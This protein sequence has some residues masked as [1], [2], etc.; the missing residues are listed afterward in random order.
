MSCFHW[1]PLRVVLQIC[2]SWVETRKLAATPRRQR[3]TEPIP[4]AGLFEKSDCATCAP[5]ISRLPPGSKVPRHQGLGEGDFG[6][7]RGWWIRDA[8][9]HGALFDHWALS[10]PLSGNTSAE[11]PVP[12]THHHL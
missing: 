6:R 8:G 1:F 4:F 7:L 3:F 2:T 5:K 9:V 10:G 12:T 11:Q